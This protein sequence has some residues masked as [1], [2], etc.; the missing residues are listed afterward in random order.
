MIVRTRMAPS[1]TGEYHIGHIRTLLYNF[2]WAKKNK[3]H[4]VIRIE[5]TDRERYVEGAVDRI[6]DVISDYGLSWD[7]GPRVDGPYG[8]YFQSE[9][10]GLYKKYAEQLVESG[11][12]YYCFCTKERIDE[13]RKKQAE[14]KKL[15]GYD[16]RCRAVAIDQAKKRIADGEKFVIRLKVPDDEDLVFDDL[17]QG[18]ISFNSSVLDDQVLLKSDGFP[19][20]H[21]AVVIDDHLMEITHIIRG[22]EWIS[23]TPKHILLYRYFDWEMPKIGHLPVF[24]DPSGD[25]KMSK[26]KGSVSA[27]SFLDGG[28]LPEAL[29]NYLMLLGWNPG[30]ERE[31]FTLG[32]FV[33]AFDVKDLNKSNPKFTYEKLNWFN[34]EYIRKLDVKELGNRIEKFTTRSPEEIEKVLPIIRDR[35]VTLANFDQLSSFIFQ[36]PDINPKLLEKYQ[37]SI[38]NVLSHA[39]EALSTSWDG[40]AMESQARRFCET[41]K[42]K[43]GDY[44]MILRIMITGSTT[45]P[46]IW[47]IMELLGK[48]ET[49]QRL[50]STLN[51]KFQILNYRYVCPKKN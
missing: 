3:G 46:P 19:T 23:S 40:K 32:E 30:G 47:E 20:Y 4:F 49:L 33:E 42:L 7:E 13:L 6:L 24:L 17:V 36:K 50:S 25:G 34:G 45:T 10:L 51:S 1:P 39:V 38:K 15:P 44:F 5:D 8:P 26:R 21:L 16:R 48:D 14:E 43:V 2:A 41:N 18:K 12:A 22:S 37:S 31:L 11:K 35:L 9:R 28:Y 29:L 27:R